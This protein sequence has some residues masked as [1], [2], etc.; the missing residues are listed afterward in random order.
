MKSMMRRWFPVPRPSAR[1]QL[2]LHDHDHAAVH[3]LMCLFTCLQLS[4]LY[5]IILLGGRG[6]RAR[7]ACWKFLHRVAEKRGRF[8]FYDNFG[9][10]RPIFI[11]FSPLNSKWAAEENRKWKL[12]PPVESVATLPCE[13]KWSTIQLC[14]TVN[15]VHS[16]ERRLNTVICFYTQLN[17]CHMFRSAFRTNA[18]FDSWMHLV[19]GCINCALF[20][21]VPN[22]YPYYWKEW[23]VQQTKYCN[24]IY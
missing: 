14:S 7:E 8:Y 19:I 9:K 4:L 24:N 16:H 2:K 20:N 21:A 5:Q 10:L 3:C 13:S 23:I 11:T 15:W 18:C 22:V 12:P 17:L 6:G 1:Q